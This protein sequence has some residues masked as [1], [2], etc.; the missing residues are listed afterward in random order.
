MRKNTLLTY[1]ELIK[2]IF[3]FLAKFTTQGTEQ[4][5]FCSL[6][7]I[8]Y[9]SA[10]TKNE[11]NRLTYAYDATIAPEQVNFFEGLWKDQSD[12]IAF[13]GLFRCLV[14]LNVLKKLWFSHGEMNF[15]YFVLFL[16]AFFNGVLANQCE[17]EDC[18]TKKCRNI[19][20]LTENEPS[21]IYKR[22]RGRLGNQLNG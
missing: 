2:K 6:T 19:K 8:R 9:L 15:F 12:Y 17:K 20:S 1:V 13:F 7:Y 4:T 3:G 18:S 22:M 10:L 14:Y 5:I 21:I 11:S 16:F